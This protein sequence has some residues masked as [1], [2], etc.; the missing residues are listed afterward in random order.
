MSFIIHVAISTRFTEVLG[1][2]YAR[3]SDQ[4]YVY[5][6]DIIVPTTLVRFAKEALANVGLVVN[7]SKSYTHQTPAK[8]RESC[9]GDYF[10]GSE[11]APIRLKLTSNVGRHGGDMKVEKC[12]SS[13]LQLERH[14][15]QLVKAGLYNL[16]NLIYRILE[17]E[18]GKLPWVTGLSP[19]LGRYT[20]YPVQACEKPTGLYRKEGLYLPMPVSKKVIGL[21]PY[22]LLGNFLTEKPSEPFEYEPTTFSTYGLKVIIPRRIRVVKRRISAFRRMA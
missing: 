11:V 21:D 16:A 18:Y 12:D 22:V 4:V 9:G 6:D 17:R 1:I 3:A 5:G 14:C 19:V 8:F 15:R 2:D 7:E 13:F 20:V 10:N